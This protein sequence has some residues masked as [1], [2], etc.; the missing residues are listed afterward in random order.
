[1][2]IKIFQLHKR[3]SQEYIHIQDRYAIS[4]TDNVFAIAD[5]T[6]QSFKSEIWAKMLVD[7]FVKNP[8]FNINFYFENSKKLAESFTNLEFEYNT[9]FA[10]ASLEKKKQQNGGTATFLGIKFIDNNKFN[11]LSCGDSCL[12]V[13]EDKQ[14]TSYPFKNLDELDANQSFLNT[15]KLLTEIENE[16]TFNT[17]EI[18]FNSKS[19]IVIAT[20][21]FSRLLFKNP[22]VLNAI[23]N[24]NDF[25]SFKIVIE[26]L[27][28]TNK[29]E[30]DDISII[31]IEPIEETKII[32]I[33]PPKDFS[34]PKIEEKEFIPFTKS[35][36]TFLEVENMEQINRML[37]HLIHENKFIKNKLKLTHALLY[38]VLLLLVLN[39]AVLF[40]VL[41]KAKVDED[42][43]VEKIEKIVSKSRTDK[44]K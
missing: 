33:L 6:T 39:F 14:V 34:F 11:F 44:N 29:L 8:I 42:A 43:N 32:E 19:T 28:N 7:D 17:N 9:N 13:F 18:S 22:S 40:Y 1:M 16:I 23:Y 3:A 30:E 26:D 27:W 15:S 4:S 35:S 24:L 25:E 10:I 36:Q 37:E 5:G 41:K 12:F 2:R 38:S 31:L 20:D 21:A